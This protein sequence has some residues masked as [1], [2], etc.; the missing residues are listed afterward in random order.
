MCVVG[1]ETPLLISAY[2]AE[3]ITPVARSVARLAFSVYNKYE[4]SF[5]LITLVCTKSKVHE[6]HACARKESGQYF[7]HTHKPLS[8]LV[9]LKKKGNDLRACG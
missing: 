7:E 5:L 1:M 4:I 9:T 2:G 6:G 3:I 8:F